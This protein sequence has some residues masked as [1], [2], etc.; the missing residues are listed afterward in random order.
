MDLVVRRAGDPASL[1]A[2]IQSEIHSIDPSVPVFHVATLARQMEGF[3]ALRR[4]QTFLIALFSAAALL[5][6][7]IGLFGLMHYTVLQRKREI[8]IRLALG[9]EPRGVLATV[10]AQGLR[11]VLA[12]AAAGTIGG[13]WLVRMISALLFQVRPMDPVSWSAAAGLLILAGAA[14]CY[15]PAR[16]AASTDPLNSLR[17][18][19]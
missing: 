5:L 16:S 7:S 13:I 1:A 18:H 19:G 15:V 14:A 11:L 8:G 9:A 3:L 17:D 4:F 2:A 12:G 6:A 10:L